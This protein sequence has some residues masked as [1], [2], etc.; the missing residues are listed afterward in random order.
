[1]SAYKLSLKDKKQLEYKVAEQS[2]KKKKSLHKAKVLEVTS[3]LK[4]YEKEN[5]KKE[6][7]HMDIFLEDEV[8]AEML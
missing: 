4:K 7:E 3:E 6:I 2:L 8:P 5:M 1:L